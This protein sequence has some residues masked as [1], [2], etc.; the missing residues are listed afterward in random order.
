MN[1]VSVI[2]FATLTK[3]TN[4]LN[5][6]PVTLKKPTVKEQTEAKR[7]AA[8]LKQ[9]RSSLEG[10][11]AVVFEVGGRK[12][13]VPRKAFLLIEKVLHEVAEGKS[14][15]ISVVNEELTTQEAADLLQVSRP[16]LVKLLDT[17]KIP[18]KKVGSHRRVKR[19]EVLK[20]ESDLKEIRRKGLE[21]LAKEAQEMG[22]G[23]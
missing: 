17:G 7:S 10:K 3:S 20:Y 11:K 2:A 14:V 18:S 1:F 9:V 15:K 22:L 5:I 12:I 6:M 19:S 16:H 8:A 4:I 23:Y 13:E 21:F